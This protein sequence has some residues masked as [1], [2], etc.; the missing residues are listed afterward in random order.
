MTDANPDGPLVAA[1]EWFGHQ[2]VE[3]HAHVA[4]ADRSWTEKVCAMVGARDGSIGLGFGVGK[5]TNRNVFDGYAGVSRGREQWTVR[6]SRRLSDEPDVLGVGPIRYEVLEPYRRVRF[7]CAPNDVVPVAF[8]WT[9]E[10]VVP[11]VLEARDRSRAGRAVPARRR[12]VALPP[13][14][15]RHRLGRGRRR[16]PRDHDR[17]LVLDA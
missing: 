1:D 7:S 14:R 9:F 6:G 10:A 2:I 5:Y 4:E 16:T 13:D 12:R 17:R 11:P 3:T 8:E 15:R